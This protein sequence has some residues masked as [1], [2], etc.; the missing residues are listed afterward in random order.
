MEKRRTVVLSP[1]RAV[2]TFGIGLCILKSQRPS[3]YSPSFFHPTLS[4]PV[5]EGNHD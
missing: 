5:S 3:F 4:E 1:E 2:S